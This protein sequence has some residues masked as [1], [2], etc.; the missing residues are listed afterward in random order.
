M[1]TNAQRVKWR[2]GTH[3][4][5][6]CWVQLGKS[7]ANRKEM[8]FSVS[9][10]DVRLYTDAVASCRHPEKG[11]IIFAAKVIEE[12][13]VIAVAP[14]SSIV[15]RSFDDM[16]EFRRALEAV[17]DKNEYLQHCCP[18]R[19]GKICEQSTEHWCAFFSHS[20]DPNCDPH[21]ERFTADEFR[22]VAVRRIEKGEELTNNYDES[23]GYER[24]GGEQVMKDFLA[25]CEEHGVEKRPSKLTLPPLMVTVLE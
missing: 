14:R 5:M 21:T 9:A 3:Q 12:G 24:H 17:E 16:E 10:A 18:S 2:S 7:L 6:A 25:L 1:C 4:T 13:E 23:V 19:S 15:A 22:I 11:R 8:S 20:G